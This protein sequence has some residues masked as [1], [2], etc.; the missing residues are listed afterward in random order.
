[1]AER[2]GEQRREWF[3]PAIVAP[4]GER[5]QGVAMIALPPRDDA[6]A[7]R[8]PDL[9]EILPRELERGLGRFR[10][11]T[12]RIGK[13]KAARLVPDQFVGERLGNLGGEETRMCVRECLR[14]ERERGEHER[15]LMAEA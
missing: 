7:L 9:E 13:G 5:A 12:H 14:L 11:A 4:G 10:A 15:V 8:L 6:G 3:A 1:M 2:A